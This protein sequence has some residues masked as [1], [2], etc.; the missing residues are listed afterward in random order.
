MGKFSGKFIFEL[1][2]KINPDSWTHFPV[3]EENYKNKLYTVV[4]VVVLK[5]GL[6][7]WNV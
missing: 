1:S 5:Y 6:P 2:P 3:E 4:T 7:G